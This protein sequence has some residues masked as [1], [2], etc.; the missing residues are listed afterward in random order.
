MISVPQRMIGFYTSGQKGPLLFFIGG[1]HGNE[2]AGVIALQRVFNKLSGLSLPF[3]GKFV[4]VCGNMPALSNGIRYIDRDLNRLWSQVEINRIKATPES[5]LNS[6]EKQLLELLDIIESTFDGS[7]SPE[8]LIDLHTTSASNGLFS[9]VTEDADNARL[10]S[11]LYAP[12]ILRLTDSLAAT[13]NI[14][15]KNRGY[16]SLAFEAGQHADPTSIDNHEA[17]IWLLLEATGCLH[18][19]DVPEFDRWQSQLIHASKGLPRYVEVIYRHEISMAD[20]YEMYPGFANYSK[21][22]AGDVVAKDLKGP[23]TAPADGMMLM[24]LYQPQG[25]EG[26]FLIQELEKPFF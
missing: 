8:I 6:E 9:I 2:P 11:S 18:K 26:F 22:K 25:E 10:A 5:E 7:C 12:V 3:A 20:G 23:V 21:V 13:T 16:K 19:D 24:P 14:F 4:G 15:A 17:A 1:I